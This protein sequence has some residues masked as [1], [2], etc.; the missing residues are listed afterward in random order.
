VL[1]TDVLGVV[2]R[3]VP[4]GGIGGGAGEPRPEDR[5]R[6]GGREVVDQVPQP[7]HAPGLEHPCDPLQRDPLPEVGDLVQREIQNAGGSVRLEY[8]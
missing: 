4:V 7:R 8:R 5:V 3:R 2:G 1:G 6:L